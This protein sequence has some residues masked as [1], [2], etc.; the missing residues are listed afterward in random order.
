MVDVTSGKLAAALEGAHSAPLQDVAVSGDARI[1]ATA[2]KDG[3]VV[4]WDARTARAEQRFDV[5]A[6]ASAPLRAADSTGCS[7]G[8]FASCVALSEDGRWVVAG[9][10]A[11]PC[12]TVWST[13]A[14]SATARVATTAAPQA[15]L[16]AAD[17]SCDFLVAYAAPW[18]CRYSVGGASRS[19]RRVAPASCLALAASCGGGGDALLA[20]GGRGGVLQ[21]LPPIGSSRTL[22]VD[23]RGDAATA[24]AR[25]A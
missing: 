16:F 4:L 8:R 15:A 22:F 6:A 20:I 7:K 19:R 24:A 3:T 13:V 23:E 17:G 2:S 9:G 10:G 21:L 25:G 18:L 5:A 11:V 14:R 12:V 1:V